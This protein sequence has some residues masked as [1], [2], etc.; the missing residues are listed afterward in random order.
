MGPSSN[1]DRRL[2]ML[3]GKFGFRMGAFPVGARVVK[4]GGEGLYGRPLSVSVGEG[5][6][7]AVWGTVWPVRPLV[8]LNECRP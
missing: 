5:F 7:D 2:S 1:L 6:M 8:P 4:G 3:P